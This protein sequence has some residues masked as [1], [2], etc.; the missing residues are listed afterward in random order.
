MAMGHRLL[1]QILVVPFHD[2]TFWVLEA[3]DYSLRR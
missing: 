1:Y 2:C 3:M